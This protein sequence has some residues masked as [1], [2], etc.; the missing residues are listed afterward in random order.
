L[1]QFKQDYGA[2]LVVC[3]RSEDYETLANRLNF[4]SGVYLRPLN[5]EQVYHYLDSAGAELNG[6]REFLKRDTA[7]Q[8]LSQSPLILNIMTLAYQ[9]VGV[10]DLPQIEVVEEQRK[11]LFDDYIQKMFHRPN[12]S[13]VEHPYSEVQ[14]KRWLSWLAHRMIQESQSEFFIEKMQPNWLK[15]RRHRLIYRLIVG[16][17]IGLMGGLNIGLMGGLFSGLNIRLMGGLFF[18]LSRVLMGGLIFGLNVGLLELLIAWQNDSIQT[19]EIFHFNWKK[20]KDGLIIGLYVG[21]YFGLSIGL[22]IGLIE[23]LIEG[24]TSGLMGGLMCGLMVG[25]MFGLIRGLESS[26]I[27]TKTSSN[28]GIWKSLQNAVIVVL[29]GGLIIGLMGGLIVGLIFGL[30]GGVNIEVIEMV[31]GGLMG[32]LIGWL[33]GG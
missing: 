24:L 2:E 6:L 3:S 33:M 31:T 18:G 26:E 16:L 30:M 7:L 9:G 10:E 14:T 25:L 27:E 29:M 13:K 23:G 20:L 17:I 8:E 4:Q 12:R 5:E 19:F 32:G 28:Q 22:S 21:L 1:N 15:N 11:Q